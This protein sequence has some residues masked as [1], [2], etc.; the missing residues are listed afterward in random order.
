[1]TNPELN[2]PAMSLEK[3]QET[4]ATKTAPKITKESIEAAIAGTSYLF[5]DHLTIAVIK[6]KNGFMH[7][8]K[9]APASPENFDAEVGKRLA[10]DDAFRQIWAFEGYRLCQQLYDAKE[11]DRKSMELKGGVSEPVDPE[12]KPE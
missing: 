3:A 11:A 10:F 6:M 8:G 12:K 2:A 4:V 5:H 7:I 9:S 1:M